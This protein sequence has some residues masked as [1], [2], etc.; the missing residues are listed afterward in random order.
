VWIH[1]AW[2]SPSSAL[3]PSGGTIL[4]RSFCAR[5]CVANALLLWNVRD[6]S[7]VSQEG[8]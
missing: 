3:L 5:L 4:P 6:I 7:G 1:G 8:T 2:P